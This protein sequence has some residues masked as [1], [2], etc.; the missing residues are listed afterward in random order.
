MLKQRNGGRL[1]THTRTNQGSTIWTT[2]HIQS[3]LKDTTW[4]G[5][6]K[7]NQIANVN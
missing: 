5:S 6:A 3:V 1:A 7:K 2:A 4:F